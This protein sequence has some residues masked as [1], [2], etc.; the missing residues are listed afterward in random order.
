MVAIKLESVLG[1]MGVLSVQKP[2]YKSLENL[3]VLNLSVLWNK[4]PLFINC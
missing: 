2:F 3:K 1:I 4:D